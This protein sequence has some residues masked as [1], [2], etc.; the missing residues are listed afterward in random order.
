MSISEELLAV[1]LPE[2]KA[3]E[4]YFKRFLLGGGETADERSVRIL[5]QLMRHAPIGV[6]VTDLSDR[7][8]L[9]NGVAS[10]LLSYDREETPEITW[11]ELR[12]HRIMKGSDGNQISD[13]TDPMRTALSQRMSITCDITYRELGRDAED[14]LS[15][16]AYPIFGSI[17]DGDVVA[18]VMNMIDISDYH[19]LQDIVYHQ[20]THDLLTGLMN[21]ASLSSNMT[22]AFARAKR[23]GD[24]VAML[25][26]D[27]DRFSAVNDALGYSAGDILLKKIGDRLNTV[28]RDTDVA[29][30]VGSNEFAILISDI[31]RHKVR[32]IASEVSERICRNIERPFSLRGE[33]AHVTASVGICV[34]PE[35]A[36]DEPRLFN[37][38]SMAMRSVKSA[39][40]NG[41]KFW[42]P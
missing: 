14:W 3:W 10:D 35:S 39:G 8:I 26:V 37:R 1:M 19:G 24:A 4:E 13:E 21:R 9:I 27:I 6:V 11:A 40:G 25:F 23:S 29:A 38:S 2:E 15:V 12:K 30:R 20:T 22:K 5:S 33:E 41:W 28:V 17:V 16:T 36:E 34:F 7:V 31:P 32:K 42:E 18:V